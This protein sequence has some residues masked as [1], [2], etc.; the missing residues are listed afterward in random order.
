MDMVHPYQSPPSKA[1]QTQQ[2]RGHKK[3][4]G[5]GS[6]GKNFK[7]LPSGHNSAVKHK[8]RAASVTYLS[9]MA[10]PYT[11]WEALPGPLPLG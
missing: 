7:I 5:P 3:C 9:K 4:Y 6:R 10:S 2:K 8:L 1:Q 11:V